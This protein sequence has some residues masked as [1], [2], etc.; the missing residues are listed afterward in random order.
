VIAYS[1]S[2]MTILT[3]VALRS[4]ALRSYAHSLAWSPLVWLSRNVC[5]SLLRKITHGQLEIIDEGES[6]ICGQVMSST[7]QPRVTLQVHK[8]TF[9]VRLLLFADMVRNWHHDYSTVSDKALTGLRRII[10]PL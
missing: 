1:R 4:Y 5:L 9:W 8:E 6:T 10:S 2:S 7:D 3:P